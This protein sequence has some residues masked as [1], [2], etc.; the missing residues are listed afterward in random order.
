[1]PSGSGRE[2]SGK[3]GTV[4][5]WG[6]LYEN[7][8]QPSTLQQVDLHIWTNSECKQKYGPT[9]PGGNYLGYYFLR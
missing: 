1:M 6:S 2:Y 8:Q 5:G 4:A 7:G 9:A 3:I